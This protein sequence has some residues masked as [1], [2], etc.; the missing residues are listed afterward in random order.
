MLVRIGETSHRTD[1]IVTVKAND[2]RESRTKVLT[3]IVTAM[4]IAH[5]VEI[6]AFM[7]YLPAFLYFCFASYLKERLSQCDS[8]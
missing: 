4:Q 5:K 3:S 7:I 1:K 8:Y 6:K 2:L